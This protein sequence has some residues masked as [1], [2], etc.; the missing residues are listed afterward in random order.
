[1]GLPGEPPGKRT[2]T[3][4]KEK[5]S[6]NIRIP[7]L[8]FIVKNTLDNRTN[9]ES[10]IWS[11]ATNVAQNTIFTL[12]NSLMIQDSED[13]ITCVCAVQDLTLIQKAVNDVVYDL[14]CKLG[15]PVIHNGGDV[16]GW[17]CD[18]DCMED[19]TDNSIFQYQVCEEYE[20]PNREMEILAAMKFPKYN[21]FVAITATEV[22]WGKITEY[23]KVNSSI[24]LAP[25]NPKYPATTVALSEV[26][27]LYRVKPCGNRWYFVK[28][29]DL[30]SAAQERRASAKRTGPSEDIIKAP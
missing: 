1:V 21:K 24:T 11:A 23:R 9:K 17:G 6:H 20:A 13:K 16:A 29:E 10:E 27:N 4:V 30:L 12:T 15:A 22:I 8:E 28:S 2:H 14:L 18:T 19:G 3:F 7:Y 26:K 25:L 5:K